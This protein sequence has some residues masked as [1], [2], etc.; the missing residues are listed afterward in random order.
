MNKIIVCLGVAGDDAIGIGLAQHE[1]VVHGPGHGHGARWTGN[2]ERVAVFVKGVAGQLATGIGD[3]GDRL[4]RLGVVGEGGAG[5]ISGSDADDG[6][7]ERRNLAIA[8]LAQDGA[9]VV[10][11][12]RGLAQRV[13]GVGQAQ[14][15]GV[16][17]VAVAVAVAFG[18]PDA[19][20]RAILTRLPN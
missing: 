4:L 8:E 5:P 15:A 17:A 3:I 16:V 11:E 12:L 7:F 2:G 1:H 18:A 9:G 20:V 14:R 13:G 6:G 10:F 19:S